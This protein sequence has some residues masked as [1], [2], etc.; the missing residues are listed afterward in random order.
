MFGDAQ[1]NFQNIEKKTEFK[2]VPNQD[3]YYEFSKSN[4]T[5]GNAR[6]ADYAIPAKHKRV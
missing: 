1:Y 5:V 2:M 6:A 3:P 4:V